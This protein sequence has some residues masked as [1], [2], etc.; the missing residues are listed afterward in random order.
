[1]PRYIG[2]KPIGTANTSVTRLGPPIIVD[3]KYN[4][5]IWSLSDSYDRRLENI[6][7]G[8][9]DPHWANVVLL[10]DFEGTDGSTT[11]TD[12]SNSAHTLTAVGNAQIDTAQ[13]K[14]G[15]ASGLFD[16][17]GDAVRAPAGTDWDFGS[18]SF[19]VEAHVRMLGTT[20]APLASCYTVGPDEGLTWRV[21]N[22]GSGVGLNF[23]V[24]AAGGTFS[25]YED[26][27][28]FSTATW[29]HVAVS[30]DGTTLRHFV[31]GNLL[32]SGH[33]PPS[34]NF[35]SGA[36]FRIGDDSGGTSTNGHID[37]FRVTKG[38]AR[39]T[40]S[41]TPPAAAYPTS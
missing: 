16:T 15:T 2:Y 10:C 37:N 24:A 39:Y 5:G 18:G 27:F 17:S 36:F 38:V 34:L 13:F 19:T 11:F 25:N 40:S 3:R 32:G 1:M 4:S 7:P 20:Y 33:T 41:F 9:V 35:T 8:A 21:F 6:W 23:R 14:Y 30:F 29:Y 31:D 22:A 26:L 12:L 28:S